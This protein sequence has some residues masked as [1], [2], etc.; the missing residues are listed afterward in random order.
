MAEPPL[1]EAE[2][3]AIAR[4]ARAAL[5]AAVRGERFVPARDERSG[6]LARPGACF[7]TLE[8]GHRLRG[9]IG[10]IEARRTL[11][12]DVL[13]N[14]RAAALHDPRFSPVA[15]S[16]LAELSIHVSVLTAPEPLEAKSREQ[17]LA[18]LVP[19]VDGLVIEQLARRATFLPAVWSTLPDPE[20]FV[21]QLERK[22]GLE[23]GSWSP[24]RR[25]FR[26]RAESIDAG[27]ALD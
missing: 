8:S 6:R 25:T 10:S 19:G 13:A 1:S 21:A 16:E 20:T 24:F 15:A 3:A 22:A 5:V 7:V 4:I 12:D 17:L 11:L 2:R 26:Y 18:Q 23:P 14:A 27:R 9:C